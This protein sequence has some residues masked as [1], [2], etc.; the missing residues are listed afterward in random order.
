MPQ[1]CTGQELPAFSVIGNGTEGA[2]EVHIISPVD[3][4]ECP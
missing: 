3:V 4:R 2:I 1:K